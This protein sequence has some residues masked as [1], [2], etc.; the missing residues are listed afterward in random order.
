MFNILPNW[1]VKKRIEE[2]QRLVEDVYCMAVAL[3]EHFKMIKVFQE[4]APNLSSRPKM[5]SSDALD[6]FHEMK[7]CSKQFYK[8]LQIGQLLTDEDFNNLSKAWK[9]FFIT[10]QEIDAGLSRSTNITGIDMKKIQNPLTRYNSL[11]KIKIIEQ[12]EKSCTTIQ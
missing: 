11:K 6:I 12:E 4:I 8:Y 1:L 3:E 5:S 7:M 10:I 9:E 2:H